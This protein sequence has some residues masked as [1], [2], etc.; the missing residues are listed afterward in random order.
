MT[1]A[2]LKRLAEAAT[3]GPWR[4]AHYHEGYIQ[5]ETNGEPSLCVLDSDVGTHFAR[6]ADF[7]AAANPATVLRLLERIAALREAI[8]YAVTPRSNGILTALARALA[9]D[10]ARMKEKP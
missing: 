2:H 5:I 6:N 8:T 7:I 3:P 4:A 9:A 1:D 10:D